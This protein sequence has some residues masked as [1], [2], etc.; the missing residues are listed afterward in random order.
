MR[1]PIFLLT[2]DDGIHV[3]FLHALI[4]ALAIRGTVYVAAPKREQS[5]IGKAVSR[6]RE[7]QIREYNELENCT[8]WEVDGTPSDA[9]NIALGHLLPETPDVVVSGINVGWNAMVPIIY[10]SGT[11]SGALEGASW[12]VPAV[13]LSMH[14]LHGD[15]EKIKRDPGTPPASLK[16]YIDTS[17]ELGARFAAEKAGE[18]NPRGEVYNVNFPCRPGTDTPWVATRPGRIP[19]DSLF[20]QTSPG[21]FNF[22]YHERHPQEPE[23]PLPGDFQTLSNGKISVSILNFNDLGKEFSI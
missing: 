20:T 23:G 8:A 21:V 11:V 13:A 12:G 5:W 16:S 1:K 14:L 10:S 9:V 17:A 3:Y 6:H 4:N 7:V 18:G 15:F 22:Q 2:N 19:F